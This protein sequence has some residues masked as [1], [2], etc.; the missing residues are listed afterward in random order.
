MLLTSRDRSVVRDIA[1]SHIL[2]RD[3]LIALGYFSSITRANTRL[4]VLR[5]LGFVKKLETPF[6]SQSLYMAG[7]NAPELA[8][9]R[10]A[11]LLKGRA[12]SP[13]F[14]QHALSVTAI[15]IALKERGASEWRFEA[16]LRRSFTDGG[17]T[18]EVRPDG[19]AIGG[20]VPLAIEADMGHAA[21]PKLADK[22]AAFDRF[23]RSG[24][25][26]RAWGIRQFNL[27]I[28]T[29]GRRRARSIEEQVPEGLVSRCLVQTFT[30]LGAVHVG[31][32]S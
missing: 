23:L 5:E 2:S 29:T 3:Q 24:E 15:R 21:L 6:F 10:I 31:G 25:S 16:Q 12:E 4:R 7:V 14:L 20:K 22:L 1:L 18:F 27:L 8:G 30:E 19:M 17:K 11:A 32:W 26:E 28:V 13:R 9:E